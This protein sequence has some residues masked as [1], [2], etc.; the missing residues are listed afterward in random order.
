MRIR[1][2]YDGNLKWSRS[3]PKLLKEGDVEIDFFYVSWQRKWFV[4]IRWGLRRI[5]L[6]FRLLLLG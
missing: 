4:A 3:Y 2:F 1:K 6:D 5:N